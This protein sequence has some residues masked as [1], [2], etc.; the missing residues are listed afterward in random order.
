M[1]TNNL[2]GKVT[3][4]VAIAMVGLVVSCKDN[5]RLSSTDASNAAS[6]SLTDSYYEDS[7]DISLTATDAAT[8]TAKAETD[9]RLTCATITKGT[10]TI[11]INFGTT[12]CTDPR[13][14]V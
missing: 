12:G 14:N 10:G 1:K 11:D 9:D 8:A 6:E 5:E 3:A 13:G 4:F 2:F 7:D